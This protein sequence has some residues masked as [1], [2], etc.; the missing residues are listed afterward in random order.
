MNC[1]LTPND[2]PIIGHLYNTIGTNTVLYANYLST[3]FKNDDYSDD[4]KAWHKKEFKTEPDIKATEHL[5][6]MANRIKKYYL[7][8]TLNVD[9]TAKDNAKENETVSLG[10]TSE[11][12]R[13]KAHRVAAVYGLMHVMDLITEKNKSFDDIINEINEI[14]KKAYEEKYKDADEKPE[15]KKTNKKTFVATI[16]S[17]EIKNELY[18]R[19]LD[20]GMSE[21]D[22]EAAFDNND[23]ASMEKVFGKN[24]SVPN[25][26]FLA[27][28]KEMLANRDAF[29]TA[30][31]K[32]QKLNDLRINNDD[33]FVSDEE[34][35]S[36]EN[37]EENTPEE[38]DD[39]VDKSKD[40]SL[41]EYNSHSGEFSSFMKHL[42]NS[43]KNYFNTLYVLKNSERSKDAEGY[44]TYNRD[45]DNELGV[46]DTM[47][48]NT[49][50]TVLY[51][52][53]DFTNVESMI[54]EIDNIA[55]NVPGMACFAKFADDLRN[56][57]DFAYKIKSIFGKYVAAKQET[58]KEGDSIVCKRSN[59]SSDKLTTLKFEFLNSVKFTC[60][61]QNDLDGAEV[62]KKG[63]ELSQALKEKV[64]K[65]VKANSLSF[66]KTK[67]QAC[68]FL[69]ENLKKFFP[70]IDEHAISNYINNNVSDPEL[71]TKER[72]LDNFDRLNGYVNDIIK[73]SKKTYSNYMNKM[74]SISTAYGKNKRL[75]ILKQNGEIVR[76]EEYIDLNPLYAIDYVNDGTKSVAFN[77]AEALVK[78][79]AV[80]TELNDKNVHGNSS[81]SV[82]NNNMI[83]N[84]MTTLHN[85]VSLGHYGDYK[86]K[87]RQYDLSNI[88]IEHRDENNKIINYG[89]FKKTDDNKFVATDY[90]KELLS[91]SLFSGASD[92]NS[93]SNVVY[94]DM[95]KGDYTVTAFANFFNSEEVY[96]GNDDSS[97]IDFANYFMR[98]PS[99]APKNFLIRAPKYSITAT[100]SKDNLFHITDTAKRNKFISDFYNN[101]TVFGD[102]SD[103]VNLSLRQTSVDRTSKNESPNKLKDAVDDILLEDRN[104]LISNTKA[105]IGKPKVGDTTQVRCMATNSKGQPFYY[106]MEGK[107]AQDGNSRR[108]INAK[109]LGILEPED[110]VS[111]Q[112]NFE[113]EL[114]KLID[115]RLENRAIRLK[116][117]DR[118]VNTNHPIFKQ[119]KNIFLQE[120][121]D[122]AV[123]LDTFFENDHGIVRTADENKPFYPKFKNGFDNTEKC[124]RSLYALYHV[125]KSQ[126]IFDDKTL[127]FTGNVFKSDRLT[128]AKDSDGSFINYG[129]E[130]LDEAF[131]FLPKTTE[132]LK[133]CIRTENGPKGF[134][135]VLTEEQE[136]AV[137]NKIS[138]FIIDYVRDYQDRMAE[139]AKLFENGLEHLNT[140]TNIA[141]F[142]LNYHLMYTSFNDL[143][144]GDTKFYKPGQDFFKRAKES[145]GSGVP[146]GIVNYN[147]EF[148]APRTEIKEAPLSKIDFIR[149]TQNGE[150]K[151]HIGQY[152]KFRAV[153]VKNTVRT[154]ATIGS[155]KYDKKGNPIAFAKK[156][157]LA[158]KL[159]ESFVNEGFT[160]KKAEE[161]AFNI[162]KKYDST[163]VNDAQSFIT[164]EEWVRRIAA[165]GQLSQYKPLI[166]E[167]LDETK[168]VS[169]STLR[170]FV[171]VQK[172][173]YYDQY[174]NE[175]LHVM[176]PRQIKNAEF[177]LIPRFL[178]GTQLEEVYNLM[179]E[180]G[181]D[182]LNTVET[183]K[184][185]KCN[186]LTLWD[187]EGKMTEENIA[188]FKNNVGN[189]NDNTTSSAV[190]LFSYNYL[191][192]Q[193]ETP[194]HM[195]AENKAGLQFVKK[196]IDNIPENHRLYKYKKQFID[197]YCAN[198]KDSFNTLIKSLGLQ[199]DDNGNL[200]IENGEIKGLNYDI[201]F[202]KF[203]A[204]FERQG[205]DSNAL[206]Y[207]TLNDNPV[208]DSST[209]G[210]Y[211]DTMMPLFMSMFGSKAES[212]AQSVINNNITRQTLPGFHA[213]Q[214]TNVGWQAK[215]EELVY[216]LKADANNKNLKDNL[217][218]NEFALLSDE[219]KANYNKVKGNITASK[220]LRYHPDGEP[221]I[222]ILVP[223]SVFNFRLKDK[224][225]NNKTD[226]ELLEELQE[227]GLDKV[228]G[229][230]IPTEGKQSICVMKI[231]GFIDE[232]Y[233]ST[234]V[235]PDDWV[236]QTG[237][238]F[239]VDS[240]YAINYSSY[241]DSDGKIKKHI[242]A[243]QDDVSTQSRAARNNGMLDAAISILS[244]EASLEENLSPSGFV[245]L[246]EARDD[247]MEGTPVAKRRK[248]RSNYNF[249]DQADQQ[250]DA[251]SGLKLKGMSVMRDTFCSICN[252]V[253][254]TI[255]PLY[256]PTV[257]Y[258][259]LDGFTEKELK[260]SY[261]KVTKVKVKEKTDKEPAQY[262]FY[263]KHDTLGWSKNNRNVTGNYITNYS[264]QTTAHILDAIK[265]GPIPNVN[266]LTFQVYKLFPDLGCDY[267]TCEA[268]IMQ[269]G[270]KRIVDA[271][272]ESKSIYTF[273]SRNPVNRAMRSIIADIYKLNNKE[274]KD[275]TTIK[276]ALQE[277]DL[278]DNGYIKSLYAVDNN[279]KFTL[280]KDNI[281]DLPI[282]SSILKDRIKNTGVFATTEG[283]NTPVEE[284]HKL[285]F[286]LVIVLQ[287]RHLNDLGSTVIQYAS[288]CNPDKFGAKQSIY[289]T[290]QVFDTIN[291]LVEDSD[292]KLFTVNEN[293]ETVHFL[294]SIYPDVKLG[295]DGYISSNNMNSAYPSLNYFLKYATATSVKVNRTLFETQSASFVKEIS[296]L[297][298]LMSGER[299]VLKEAVYKDFQQYVLNYLYSNTKFVSKPISIDNETGNF[300]YKDTD[301][302]TARA[303]RR[304]IFGFGQ[305]PNHFYKKEVK[306][307]TPEGKEEI[308]LEDTPFECA[309]INEPT[310]EEIDIFNTFSPAQKISWIKAH[311]E[312]DNIF[313]YIDCVLFNEYQY[314][315]NKGGMQTISF[316][317]NSIDSE[318]A[319]TLF[320]KAYYNNNPLI[321]L[322]A[323]DIVKYAFAVEG[324]KMRKKG[325]SK[326]ISNEV[327]YADTDANG[328]GIVAEVK[329]LMNNITSN[330]LQIEEMKH[331]YVRSHPNSLNIST[332]TIDKKDNNLFKPIYVNIS[333]DSEKASNVN[334]GVIDVSNIEPEKLADYGI[335][336]FDIENN[337]YIP[338][339]YVKLRR[340]GNTTLFAIEWRSS[341]NIYLYP[342]NL[343]EENENDLFSIN[344]SNNRFRAK[345]YYLSIIDAHYSDKL[346]ADIFNEIYVNKDT[347]YNNDNKIKDTGKAIPFDINDDKFSQ[348]KNKISNHFAEPSNNNE[349]LY[350]MSEPLSHYIKSTGAINGSQQIVDGTVYDIVK[351][352][353]SL[354][355]SRY[356]GDNKGNREVNEHN[357]SLNNVIKSARKGGYKIFNL[358]MIRKHQDNA[359]DT[360]IQSKEEEF[361]NIRHSTV[362]EASV[363][364]VRALYRMDSSSE[365]K[366]IHDA[367]EF[368]RQQGI[369][370]KDGT[371]K[372]NI[373][374]VIAI[375]AECVQ[376]VAT[377][378]INDLNYFIKD[379]DGNY[380]S[381]A[382]PEVMDI[383]RNNKEAR[384]K[385][386]K[387]LNDARAF[388]KNYRVIFD[389]DINSE[390]DSLKRNL[391][392]IK[393]YI[394]DLQNDSTI[395]KAE[396]LFALDYL[397]KL[398]D[399]PFIK[400]DYGT[401]LDGYHSAS[402]FD[403]W[404]SDLQETSNPLIQI[405]TKDVMADIRGAELKAN[406]T[407]RELRDKINSIKA[408]AKAAGMTINWD[409]IIDKNGKFIQE[410]NQAFLD[411][412]EE[413][414]ENIKA[415]EAK[416][417]EAIIN[418]N[419]DEEY[420]YGIKALK[421][422]WEFDKF[423]YNHVN[424]ELIDTYYKQKLDIEKKMLDNFST[425]YYKYKKLAKERIDI[426][427]HAVNGILSE[428][429]QDKLKEVN[430]KIKNLTSLYVFDRDYIV[431]KYEMD[432]PSNPYKGREKVLNSIES[433]QAL[434][435]YLDDMRDL[436]KEFYTYDAKYGFYEELEKNLDIVANYEN[437][438]RNGRLTVPM[439]ELIKKDE[440]VKAKQWLATNA[441]HTMSPEIRKLINKALEDL[442]SKSFVDDNGKAEGSRY[443]THKAQEHE[444]YDEYGVIDGR[445]FTD[446]EIAKLKELQQKRYNIT[447]SGA[448][449]DTMLI[450]NAPT[451]NT[452][453]KSSFYTPMTVEAA[454]NSEYLKLVNQAN[455][456][457][458]KY[459][460][461]ATKTVWTSSMSEEDMRKLDHIYISM[462]G[463][464]K[465]VKSPDGKRVYRYISENAEVIYD[466]VKFEEQRRLAESKGKKYLIAWEQLNYSLKYDSKGRLV[467]DSEG[468]GVKIPNPYLYGY[469][470][471]KGYKIDGTGNNSLVDEK[472]TKAVEVL[473]NYL[474]YDKTEYYYMKYKEMSAKGK[475]AFEAWY[476]AN[477]VYN[478]YNHTYEP[479]PCW[480]KMEINPMA[481]DG[482]VDAADVWVPAF[483]QSK[484]RV[485]NGKDATGKQVEDVN[486]ENSKDYTNHNWKK[487]ASYG[488]N[489]KKQI[490]YITSDI[491]VLDDDKSLEDNISYENKDINQNRYE[492]EIKDEFQ[493][494]LNEL[495]T[496][497][498]AKRFIQN[499]YMVS[500]AKNPEVNGKY[501]AKEVAKFVGWIEGASGRE[502]WYD[503]IDYANDKTPNM[504]MTSMFKNKD[505]YDL[506]K[507]TPI[508]KNFNSDEEY[509]KALDNY[510]SELRKAR[511]K[512]H[513]ETIDTNWEDVMEDFIRKAAHFNAVQEN[514]YM[515][516]YA[517]N[518][519]DKMDVYVKNAGFKN[520]RRD[521]LNSTEDNPAY[522]KQKDTNLQE[523]YA[524]WL[525]RLIYEQYKKPNNNLTRIA[526]LMQSFTSAKFMMLNV[527][528]GIA[529]YTVGDTQI[530][531]ERFAR[532]YFGNSQWWKASGLW[533]LNVGSFL[534]DMYSDKSSSLVSSIVKF[535][536]VV[537]FDQVTENVSIPD[538]SEYIKRARDL[539]FSPQAIGEHFMQN[540]ALIAMLF[541]HRLYVNPNKSENGRLSYEYK[542]IG[543]I[544]RDANEEALQEVMTESQKTIWQKFKEYELKDPNIKKEY[545]WARK[546]LTTEFV[547]IY[548]SN[549]EK[550]TFGNKAKEIRKAR[551]AEFNDDEKHP[552]IFSQLEL[553]ADGHLDF[554]KDSI[555]TSMRDDAFKLLG[556]LKGRVISVNK[557]IHG[558]YDKLGAAKIES[559]WWGGIVM[560][561][562]KHLYPGIMKRYRRK[563]YFNE[564]RGTIEKGCFASIK[565]FLSLP[566]HKREFAD[567]LKRDNSMT[568]S[569]LD[570]I[571]GIQNL[572]K[573]YVNFALNVKVYWDMIP[574][575]ERANIKRAL[576]DFCG[577]VSALC[578]AIAMNVVADGD[579]EDSL[580]YNL[581]IYE[582]DRLASESMMWYPWGLAAEGNKLWSS[583]V[584]VEGGISDIFHSLGFVCQWLIQGEDFD[585]YYTSGLYAGENKLEIMLKRQIPMY[586]GT[587]MLYRLQRSNKYYKLNENI[588]SIIPTKDIA[589]WINK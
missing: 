536:G 303:E 89:L 533:K 68:S 396:D 412:I 102:D 289:A 202:E 431:E 407:I 268:F 418:N 129:Q 344:A 507:N 485:K 201:L 335:L 226:N 15:F 2:A 241:I 90:A 423:K 55:N 548:F 31:F 259:S 120:L 122:A 389:L 95:S 393:K 403:A 457:L 307:T 43:I 368:L 358:Y 339:S 351:V 196:I 297:R 195:N 486:D 331:Q 250:E 9:A 520:L 178:K 193:Q 375:N 135:V 582:A 51:S 155:F 342:V 106:I 164:F 556:A 345:D 275:S 72:I 328:T 14:D 347:Q 409:N 158:E 541:S 435:E 506:E 243:D 82:L 108:L 537:D 157:V 519:L 319:Y 251:M 304:R 377:Q 516:F 27:M 221:Y 480:T 459:Y 166:D 272:N 80:K 213:P 555:L 136:Q 62:F 246:I 310:Q 265:E 197:C 245:E 216:K 24:I 225:G 564:E 577:I 545:K 149:K 371:V 148:D 432:N 36:L 123:A 233:G 489:Y 137:N 376:N 212:V 402:A 387:T 493:R 11:A 181:I 103:Y 96:N 450:T 420:K 329:T 354:F 587:N 172:N 528:G 492:R 340:K 453:F 452:I 348:D 456:I 152:N 210:S 231:K 3:V 547:N 448:Y 305:E 439:T 1:S 171:Q 4:F 444:A 215:D 151:V 398:S 255:S 399:N 177:V 128:I 360:V 288:V 287:Y 204:E 84:L 73:N 504:P 527:T 584:A 91:D 482:D 21:E 262:L 400:E 438:D 415:Y 284:I 498:S 425:V 560:Q 470:V 101:I 503:N 508:R 514:K 442:R 381:V 390:D 293:G 562:H 427:S 337:E 356:I 565:D 363:Q 185:G 544:I 280:N 282:Q 63:S 378:I 18:Y 557:K 410:Y 214:V 260:A 92:L 83:T 167:I 291:Q 218:P 513:A 424:Q 170:K 455:A 142:A 576:G 35:Y 86:S 37:Q 19:L 60:L 510:K 165:R 501:I 203:I 436:N 422:R 234:I 522:I 121:T 131:C 529:N 367:T 370:I 568:D 447:E 266:D 353:S 295:L 75:D 494:I 199:T 99:D 481:D 395:N 570:N 417:D 372:T 579:D 200:K 366:E 574:E 66:I 278:I 352:N 583:P 581:F 61:E 465:H 346:T 462:S 182:Q 382:D 6:Q 478:P 160:K 173:F 105:I 546:D 523:Q 267:K 227:A 391:E 26:N 566:L 144:E 551:E 32:N 330:S 285:L 373:D 258:S 471:P 588:L 110:N 252:T 428:E 473:N 281:Y 70:T 497:D 10:Y 572:V 168:E 269:P 174:Y 386:L 34:H 191:Y 502:T 93:D 5:I 270:I 421:E 154:G 76:A 558:V 553:G 332:H 139:K 38:G 256:A 468:K 325:V 312:G 30:V 145:Q 67:A 511:I 141:T 118:S 50:T 22:A 232:T 433:A 496:V 575:Y 401:L 488:V 408:A 585:P 58:I 98:I 472:K 274:L 290:N 253:R 169:A 264:S 298:T 180:H 567:R 559:E 326:I 475:A 521:S 441:R 318:T 224:D 44:T 40:R 299:Q 419:E 29:F 505:V 361:N 515:L 222:E 300:V 79:T 512:A 114:K 446:E 187:N 466:N 320:K 294:N 316:V 273:G 440:Y 313:N 209:G 479:L 327:L 147:E 474:V 159:I 190:E 236:S 138:Q 392:I 469:L 539:A 183:S 292:P 223:R 306:V 296:S 487:N 454:K 302:E 379:A 13:E 161:K 467:T 116:I 217:T 518:M 362:E 175:R 71:T 578:M 229:Y 580:L 140:F 449:R 257:V 388:V 150:E 156:G 85:E 113:L 28:Y 437:R 25:A 228:I 261:D 45:D 279:F 176:A 100:N 133:K 23:T 194:Q 476:D 132:D 530:I 52:Y 443:L 54:S 495:A 179:K 477:H 117:V 69:Y 301:P 208:L 322:A 524:N 107:Y 163:K 20:E 65:P 64:S 321:A 430:N 48:A 237:S 111:S 77:L 271:Y 406:K 384:I 542:N 94:A 414:R 405:V 249:L 458:E 39:S 78:F 317:E 277:I 343:L 385:F 124:G 112:N 535:F 323:A 16:I 461:P 460:D 333:K 359:I 500:R 589:D 394:G 186:V 490:S 534:K 230:R 81:S 334:T 207:V 127:E 509:E 87:T 97:H 198:I 464:H 286:D 146:Y 162:L 235:V 211:P 42:D 205:M 538:A 308:H 336:Y 314:R 429:Y 247:L 383:I 491:D 130:L 56:D 283:S 254:P 263:V 153:T 499:G 248:H 41:S 206:D 349:D 365:N 240:V 543:E 540:T 411:K 134:T 104:I 484:R 192:T 238:D 189:A 357:E 451:D 526:N 53:G 586:H 119:F 126:K 8:N 552:T 404:V 276:E 220:D 338:N 143:F 426:S 12:A 244:D 483:A 242:F 309:N 7:R 184:A 88:I 315:R 188:D 46:P 47:D 517:K 74:S 109:L 554:K 525:R 413:F 33:D 355:N 531:A 324:F 563:G 561:Y 219:D 571:Q 573:D 239:D 397:S 350:V 57:Y 59:R 549:A 532:E 434:K 341:H 416:R 364:F 463:M 115:E 445:L 311:C 49:C 550:K 569:E 369:T 374:K 17:E 380:K 125:G